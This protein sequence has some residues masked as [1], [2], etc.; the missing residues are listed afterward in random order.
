MRGSGTAGRLLATLVGGLLLLSGL[1]VLGQGG[2]SAAAGVWL[3]VVG[4]VL[5]I[6]AVLERQRYRS[7]TAERASLSA[8]P[9]GGEPEGEQLDD[10]F[11]ATAEVFIDPTSGR[12]MRVWLDPLGGERR[13][14]AEN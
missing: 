2:A 11:K 12:R 4:M 14:K 10:R 1:A 13:Y 5:I 3:A 6:A 7:E 9:G 8:G